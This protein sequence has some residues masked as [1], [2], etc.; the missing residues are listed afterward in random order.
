M[1]INRLSTNNFERTT[2]NHKQPL[3]KPQKN[4]FMKIP[5]NQVAFKGVA[6]K[7]YDNITEY[8]AKGLGKF[9]NTN[10]TKNTVKFL[11]GE[12]QNKVARSIG[13]FINIKEKW[14]QHAIA[15]ES[16]YLTSFYLR[17]TKKSKTI[18][19][20]QKRPMMINQILVTTLCTALGYTI[21]S[22]ISKLFNNAKQAFTLANVIK[23]TEKMKPAV[24]TAKKAATTPGAI[25]AAIKIPLKRAN[26]IANGISKLKSVL[27]FGFIYRYFSPVFITPIAN[28]ISDLFE[29]KS[30]N[31]PKIE[32]K[33]KTKF[34]MSVYFAS[35]KN[36]VVA[37]N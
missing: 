22:K 25:E 29:K 35:T 28:R 14:F 3:I 11:N 18:P 5:K 33:T 32:T 26:A 7:I 15:I 36:K 6:S 21:D 12:S 34:P 13:K 30:N 20:D 2:L 31:K 37:K 19:E 10:F 16:I 17:N 8:I 9:V 24:E 23:I 27:V 1:Q 4:T